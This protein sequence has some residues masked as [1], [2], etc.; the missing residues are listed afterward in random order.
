MTR[1]RLILEID[2]KRAGLIEKHIKPKG[3]FKKP[4]K[5]HWS[6]SLTDL[7]LSKIEA[8]V[9][10]QAL[11]LAGGNRD[12]TAGLLGISVRSLYR[13]LKQHNFQKGRPYDK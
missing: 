1:I 7:R 5:E 4:P 11:L 6:A 13:K 12:I 10:G 2:G 3:L 8:K 9:I